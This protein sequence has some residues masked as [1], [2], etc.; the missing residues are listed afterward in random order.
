MCLRRLINWEKA[1]QF[2]QEV[3]SEG[4]QILWVGT[5]K[6]ARDI[7]KTV[8]QKLDMPYVNYRWVGGTLSNYAQ[9]KKIGYRSFAF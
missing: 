1:S 9:V 6:P 5:K 2:L 3:A 8:A 7:V 4:K